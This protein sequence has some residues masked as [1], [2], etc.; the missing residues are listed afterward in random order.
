MTRP[1]VIGHRGAPVDAPENTML[2]FQ[3]AIQVGADMIELDIRETTDGH[4]ICLHD[5]D[6]SRTTDGEGTVSEL[7]LTEVRSLDAGQGEKIPLLEEVLDFAKGRISVNMDLKVFDYEEQILRLVEKRGMVGTVIASSFYQMT[8]EAMRELSTEIRTAILVEHDASDSVR[9]AIRIEA[10]AINPKF[11]ILTDEII[12][13][14]H[15]AGLSVFPWTVNSE[16]SMTSLL[17]REV[18]GLITDD[19]AKAVQIVK[20]LLNAEH[21]KP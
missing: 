13:E 14:T 6:V 21:A 18:D 5:E 12:H 4:L 15:G 16:E 19:P 11:N 7:T 1:I 8:L 20:T 10:N 3:R 9:D 17:K 2:S